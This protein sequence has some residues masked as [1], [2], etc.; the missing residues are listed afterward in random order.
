MWGEEQPWHLE[1]ARKAAKR[2]VLQKAF[3]QRTAQMSTVLRLTSPHLQGEVSY[4]QM[5]YHTVASA[6]NLGATYLQFKEKTAHYI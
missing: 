4:S 2:P 1:E 5:K 3:Q 6:K